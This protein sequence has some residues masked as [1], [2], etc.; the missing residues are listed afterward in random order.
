VPDVCLEQPPELPHGLGYRSSI[1]EALAKER[2]QRVVGRWVPQWL[3]VGAS[4]DRRP[5]LR[6]ASS[7]EMRN[8]RFDNLGA[9]HSVDKATNQETALFL[10]ASSFGLAM[11]SL[12]A[13]LALGDIV[14]LAQI[15]PFFALPL[16]LFIATAP[17][18]RRWMKGE[19]ER[20]TIGEAADL[21]SERRP[22]KLKRTERDGIPARRQVLKSTGPTRR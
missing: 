5:L 2:G 6:A 4:P 15:L 16:V 17:L 12:L 3:S 20:T 21:S 14:E 10:A 1:I 13:V 22:S 8:T 19:A 9:R 11:L 7:N 18:L